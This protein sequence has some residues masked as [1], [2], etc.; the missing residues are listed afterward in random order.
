MI[1]AKEELRVELINL[2][3]KYVAQDQREDIGLRLA[4]ILDKYDVAHRVTEIVPYQ[5]DETAR[6]IKQ[7]LAAKIAKGCTMRTIKYYGDTIPRTLESIGKPYDKVTADDIRLYIAKRIHTDKVSKT[8]VNNER[9]NLS[10]FYTWLQT[11]EIL[12]KNPMSKVEVLKEQKKK[13]TAY[14]LIDAERLRNA[15]QTNR[16]KAIIEILSSTW[17]RASEVVMIRWSEISGTS[18]VIHG[19]GQ[20]D[21][22]CYLNARALLAIENYRAERKD[23]NP[24]VFPRAAGA[25]DIRNFAKGRQRKKES[26]WYMDAALVDP[27]R[28]MDYSSLGDIVRTIGKRAGVE[29]CHPHRF[30][31]T[32][33]TLAL[34]SGMPL[35]TV[36]K[37]LG[38]ESIETTQIYLDISD[39]D[40][41]QAHEKYVI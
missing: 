29:K 5:E 2:A 37:L 22:I 24:Y 1:A 12:L 30:R 4:M 11:E 25:G 16:E 34:R 21:R 28:H 7:F 8:T 23:N 18:V 9:R 35:T 10:S 40:L 6:L 17:C 26:S 20:K 41:K 36:S 38:H 32:G 31:R 13:K 19:K 27:E 39:E 14:S 15:C 3:S 33:A